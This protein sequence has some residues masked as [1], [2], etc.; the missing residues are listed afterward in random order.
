MSRP[1][2][3]AAAWAAGC[4]SLFVLVY[5]AC[6][7]ITAR[8][9][10]VGALP[11]DWETSIPFVPLMIVPYWSLDLFFVASFFLCRDR[12][13]LALFGKRIVL[14][15]LAAGTC[16]LLFPLRCEFP[17]HAVGGVLGILFDFLRGFDL[18]YNQFPSLHIA[19]LTL[20]LPVFARRMKGPAR[21][22][23]FAWFGLIAASTVLTYQHHVI[24]LAGGFALA[25]VCFYVVREETVALP[26]TGNPRIGVSYA[27]GSGIALGLMSF[28]PMFAW[29]ALAMALVAAGYFGLGPGIYLKHGHAPSLS[30][31]IL[32][33]PCLL[34]QYVSW[35]YYR[36]RSR[37]WDEV[38]PGVWMG[39]QLADAEAEQAV[40]G[41]VTAVLDLTAEFSGAAPF[42]RLPYR[43]LPLLD[44]T[45]PGVAQLREAA[46]FIRE[47]AERGVVYVHCK[48][49]YSRSAAA[50]GAWLLRSGRARTSGEA[51]AILRRARPRLVVRSEARDAL[52][53]F[54]RAE[55]RP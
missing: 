28:T 2:K 13:E 4:S 8:R 20:V 53:A 17:R 50:I 44:L 34:G 22:L 43:N 23:L 52:A 25:M 35:C 26:R 3:A 47:Q 55:G 45:A 6:T 7:W 36:R 9:T 51:I 30:A 46:E 32:L 1:W 42:R 54:E 14:A 11:F 10:D 48:A 16:F 27:I 33:A 21:A 41:G 29:P 15:I 40:R 24:D 39:R 49:G 19:L 38:V 5:S 18:P 31:R 37:P 12:G